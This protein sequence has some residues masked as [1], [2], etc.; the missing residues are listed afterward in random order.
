MN[1]NTILKAK[2]PL[3]KKWLIVGMLCLLASLVS[4]FRADAQIVV[5][6]P[7]EWAALVEGNE[8][9]NAQFKNEIKGQTKTAL[10]QNTIAAEFTQIKK[11]EKKYNSYLKTTEGFA[12]QIKAAS[13]LYN[14]GVRLFINLCRL[15]K[16]IVDNPQ[17]I[18]ATFSMNDLYMET[19][20]ELVTVY[21]TLKNAVDAGGKE[22]MLTGAQRSEILWSI[23]DKLGAFNHKLSQLTLSLQYYTL[24]DVW[25]NATEGIIDRDHGEIAAQACSRWMRAAKLRY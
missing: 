24:S 1:I 4:T 9:I 19:A 23:T 14:D 13:H 15:R 16:A 8:L 12:S 20:A 11:W 22:N 25:Y 10:L 6:N 2:R 18:V 7:L 17:G 3:L 5:V 21:S